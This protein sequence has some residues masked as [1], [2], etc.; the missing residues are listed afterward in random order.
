MARELNRVP[1]G[2]LSI[3]DMKARGDTPRELNPSLVPTIDILKLYLLQNRESIVGAT[4][5]ITDP[6]LYLDV[7]TT[8]PG[9][10]PATQVP[11]DELWY[12]HHYTQFVI[13]TDLLPTGIQLVWHPA[14]FLQGDNARPQLCFDGMHQP[15]SP[16]FEG[17]AAYMQGRNHFW[18]KPGD[19]SAAWVGVF[20][21]GSFPITI[22]CEMSITRF[23]I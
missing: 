5:T 12:V 9:G 4:D 21:A 20:T 2:L 6:G 11:N 15:T 19:V 16:W 7:S 8:G 10:T 18:M 14:L 23:L 13:T 17:C 22:G 3:L 1:L